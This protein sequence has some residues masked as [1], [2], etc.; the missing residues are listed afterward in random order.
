MKK[1]CLKCGGMIDVPPS[2]TVEQVTCSFCGSVYKCVDG[3][4]LTAKPNIDLGM[5]E[6]NIEKR[7]YAPILGDNN[8]ELA[9]SN[10]DGLWKKIKRLF[11][12]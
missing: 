7:K 4:L 9:D 11:G 6:E 10:S 8:G 1:R 12:F 2:E 3:T 5:P